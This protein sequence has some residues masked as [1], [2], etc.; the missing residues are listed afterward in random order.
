MVKK[1]FLLGQ[2]EKLSLLFLFVFENI[3]KIFLISFSKMVIDSLSA[4]S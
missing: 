1:S 4:L 3:L 2:K